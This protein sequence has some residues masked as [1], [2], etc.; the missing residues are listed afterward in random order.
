MLIADIWL[1]DRPF[2]LE[3]NSEGLATSA[4]PAA[5]GVG[6][7]GEFKD[8]TQWSQLALSSWALGNGFKDATQGG[9]LYSELDT[10]FQ[11][12][13]KL[14]P[15]VEYVDLGDPSDCQSYFAE[16]CGIVYMSYGNRVYKWN[17][18][19]WELILTLDH[20][21]TGLAV[22][23]EYLHIGQGLDDPYRWY[24]LINETQGTAPH[25]ADGFYAW[26]GFLYSWCCNVIR[27]TNGGHSTCAELTPPPDTPYDPLNPAPGWQ[28]TEIT[29]GVC[30]TCE[31]V[32][33]LAG[34]YLGSL[35][36]SRL[37][38]ATPSQLY[39]ILPGDV[40]MSLISWPGSHIAN[41]RNML[42]WNGSAYAPV[43]DGLYRIAA[44]GSII[45]TGINQGE[46]L[47]CDVA[48]KHKGLLA[49][50]HNLLSLVDGEDN[51]LWAWA[52][53]WHHIAKVPGIANGAYY[54]AFYERVFLPLA[55]GR[56]ASLA[57]VDQKSLRNRYAPG[58]YIDLGYI[59]GGLRT[60]QKDFHDVL[61]DGEGITPDTPVAVYWS[62][63]DQ[64]GCTLPDW[65]L[66][67]V[68]KE[69]QVKLPWPCSGDGRPQGKQI[70]LWVKLNTTD[71]ARSPTVRNVV[72]RF[73]PH[74][75]DQA[76]WHYT[77]ELNKDCMLDACGTEIEDYDQRAWD[78]AIR[79][80]LVG[81]QPVKFK[82]FDGSEYH[83]K[84]M[85][86]ARRIHSREVVGED[87]TLKFN[88]SWSLTLVQA[89]PE[90]LI[91]C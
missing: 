33:G 41:G 67:G 23:D 27:Y 70:R 15:L 5:V 12:K 47:P 69:N 35:G 25:C 72:V 6:G 86:W 52:E 66:L 1:N 36:Q 50:T 60:A 83:V 46:G 29:V 71:P 10:R 31:C 82:D 84:V 2:M 65:K 38:V 77:I 42:A 61:I 40:V 28:W 54:S 62:T 44:D 91:V 49:T 89:C 57:L 43:G 39:A 55:T 9:F 20:C 3:G 75:V 74:V 30:D 14:P 32:N 37:Y 19:E 4:N 80:A 85:D 13:I 51:T 79:A 90:S 76:R 87:D 24:S 59:Y 22:F 64:D 45:Q 58:G 81:V 18:P 56:V 26:G 78:C 48:G 17:D 8:Y 73:L 68:A 16:S 21:V 88:I 63:A 11:G 7:G 34:V 53:G